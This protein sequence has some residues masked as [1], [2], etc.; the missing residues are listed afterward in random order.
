MIPCRLNCIVTSS[1]PGTRRTKPVLRTMLPW[2]NLTT[3]KNICSWTSWSLD[4]VGTNWGNCVKII[5]G[6]GDGLQWR[7]QDFPEVGAPTFQG[8]PTYI[9]SNFPKNRMK[10]K[11]FGPRGASLASPIDPS[12]GLRALF[13]KPPDCL[14]PARMETGWSEL[15]CSYRSLHSQPMDIFPFHRNCASQSH[16]LVTVNPTTLWTT[17]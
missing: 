16:G 13:I 11:E 8:T 7:I 12:L 15:E 5:G 4:S 3:T 17:L 14:P 9:L 1:P 6:E 2:P 10:L